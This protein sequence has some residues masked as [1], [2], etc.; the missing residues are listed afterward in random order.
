METLPKN[1]QQGWKKPGSWEVLICAFLV[2]LPKPPVLQAPALQQEFCYSL[3]VQSLSL[4]LV[5]VAFFSPDKSAHILDFHSNISER[6]SRNSAAVQNRRK[7]TPSAT[8]GE[9]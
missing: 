5:P 7:I 1:G 8:A 9:Y 4:A 6:L 3:A 2:K